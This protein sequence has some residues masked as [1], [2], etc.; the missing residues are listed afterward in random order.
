MASRKEEKE[1]RKRARVEAEQAAAA[2]DRRRKLFAGIGAAALAAVVVVVALILV[3]QSGDDGGGDGGNLDSV[4][5]V[6]TELAGLPQ[7]GKVLGEPKAE[8]TIRE[9]GDLQCPA[10]KQFSE[11]V[12]PDLVAG[13]VSA[14]DANME[15]NN[16]VIIGPDSDVAARAALA[17]SEQDRYWQFI[18]LFY[19][20][21]GLEGSGYVTDEFLTDVAR[22]AGVPDIEAW[23]ESRADPKWDEDLA[24]T[25]AEA[26]GFGLTGTPSIVVEGPGGTEVLGTPGSA[27]EIEDAIDKVS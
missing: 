9:F 5:R 1:A 27:G 26:Q 8:V 10:C 15:F 4:D 23:D 3:S 12:T 6:D 16:F 13:P 21:Q 7:K 20:N 17:A 24:D 19:A 14:G 22:G 25:Q 2:E 18:E 11:N